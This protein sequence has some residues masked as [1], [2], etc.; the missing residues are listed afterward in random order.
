MYKT[1]SVFQVY[2][3]KMHM[4]RAKDKTNKKMKNRK[5]RKDISQRHD[6]CMRPVN[7]DKRTVR[8]LVSFLSPSFWLH[9]LPFGDI[10][11]RRQVL[12]RSW[13]SFLLDFFFFGCPASS[14]CGNGQHAS[15]RCIEFLYSHAQIELWW[16]KN[17]R[18]FKIR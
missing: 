6:N 3:M 10:I 15:R 14:F 7:S 5:E 9:Y 8:T 12:R 17:Q 4:K 2:Q 11:F 1:E 18:R 16:K 13:P